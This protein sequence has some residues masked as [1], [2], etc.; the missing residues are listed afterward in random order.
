ML[1]KVSV[2]VFS[3]GLAPNLAPRLPVDLVSSIEEG[4]RDAQSR[5]GQRLAVV[6]KGPYVLTRTRPSRA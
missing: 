3:E 5:S 1:G 2:G 4:L 6:P